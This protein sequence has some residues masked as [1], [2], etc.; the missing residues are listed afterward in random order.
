MLERVRGQPRGKSHMWKE[1]KN[2]HVIKHLVFW[3]EYSMVVISFEL[4]IFLKSTALMPNTNL[5]CFSRITRSKLSKVYLLFY[6]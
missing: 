6:K 2:Y 1:T 4:G 5:F 3:I